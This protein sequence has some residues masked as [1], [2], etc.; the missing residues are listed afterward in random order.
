MD[1]D[2]ASARMWYL[3]KIISGVIKES[4]ILL[5]FRQKYK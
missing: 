2:E 4:H 5:F 1:N 3:N